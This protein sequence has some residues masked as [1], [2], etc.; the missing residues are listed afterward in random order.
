MSQR[1]ATT[2]IDGLTDAILGAL[3]EYSGEVTVATKKACEDVAEGCRDEIAKLSPRSKG[4]GGKNG[5]YA[6]SWEKKISFQNA[7]E[8][9]YTVYNK[10]HYQLTH[11]LEY[12]HEKWIFGY[13]TG[14]RVDPKPHI[15]I[16]ESHAKDQLVKEIK[17]NL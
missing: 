12:G 1:G 8:I 6:D 7:D 17:R 16:A 9:R 13:Y 3:E 14:G 11:L 10:K 5:H 2:S 15:R 4:T